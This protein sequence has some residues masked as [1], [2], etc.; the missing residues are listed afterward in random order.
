MTK[1][2]R[3]CGAIK[4]LHNFPVAR[5]HG[6][7]RDSYCKACKNAQNR[8]YRS[9]HREEMN[10][11]RSAHYHADPECQRKRK[12]YQWSVYPKL[13]DKKLARKRE[14]AYGLP[15]D[16]YNALVARQNGRCAI[17][18]SQTPGRD[19]RH[20]Q[21]DHDHVTGKV[22]GLLC[23]PCNL[24]LGCCKDSPELLASA[25]VYLRKS[26]SV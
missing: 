20:W 16:G 10:A 5:H 6:D 22:R 2:C 13:R 17:C 8:A 14:L 23:V 7:G 24:L 9:A 15:L 1:T 12:E 3:S 18:R 25:I 11:R 21:V 26:S 4:P 19:D